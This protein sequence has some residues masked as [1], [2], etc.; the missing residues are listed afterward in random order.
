MPDNL[1][2]VTKVNVNL[3]TLSGI[4]NL[5]LEDEKSWLRQLAMI[6]KL[7]RRV[8][9]WSIK[10]EMTAQLVIGALIMAIWRRGKPDPCYT[11]RTRGVSILA[12]S[13]ND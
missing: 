8:V 2:V 7:S 4:L 1:D 13:S 11:A 3:V 9:G 6:D 10:A 12:S 5:L